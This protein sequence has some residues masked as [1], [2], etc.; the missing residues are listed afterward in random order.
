MFLYMRGDV[1]VFIGNFEKAEESIRSSR[2]IAEA[3]HCPDLI[4]YA[5]NSLGNL[6]LF[7]GMPTEAT[8]AYMIA[9]RDARR[10]GIRKLEADIL[11]GLAQ[12]SL[13]IGDTESAR[14][15]AMDSLRGSRWS[16]LRTWD[17]RNSEPCS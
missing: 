15:R 17:A 11:A 10:I 6:Y 5:N 3:G 9:L 2:S 12:L 16:I 7:Q 8:H 4:A 14:R 13:E 1:N